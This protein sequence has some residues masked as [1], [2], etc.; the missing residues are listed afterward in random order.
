MHN[1]P[2]TASSLAKRPLAHRRESRKAY[3]KGHSNLPYEVKPY[4]VEEVLAANGFGNLD[5]IHISIDPVSAR[6]PGYCFVDFPD[7]ATADHALSSLVA[8]IRGRSLKV[9]PCE[10][11]KQKPRDRRWNRDQESETNTARRWGDWSTKSGGGVPIGQLNRNGEEQGPYWALD[12]FQDYVQKEE[13]R[14]LYVGGLDK[15]INQAQHQ[16]EIHEIF[17]GF[18][19]TA[20]GK[21]ITPHEN[22]R[23]LEGKHHYCFVDFETKE[24]ADAAVQALNGKPIAGGKLKVSL[25]A[26]VPT[27]LVGRQMDIE[28]ARHGYGR[29]YTRAS[30]SRPE[31][32][33][34]SNSAMSS[35]NWRRR[36]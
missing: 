11:K 4:D 25:S 3:P 10:P 23:Q 22:T 21:R 33:A 35:N 19:P 7:R 2:S 30:D 17:A 5:K 18:D 6:N 8:T 9:G 13:G 34:E 14:R 16:R 15:M 29:G 31:N 36:D 20:V 32:K 24:E 1:I 27:K 26:G 28:S 12:H